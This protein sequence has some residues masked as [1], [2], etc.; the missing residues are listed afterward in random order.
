[1]FFRSCTIF[2]WFINRYTLWDVCNKE[3]LALRNNFRVTKKFLITMV[4]LCWFNVVTNRA[5]FLVFSVNSYVKMFFFHLTDF[6]IFF[7]H[8]PA[9]SALLTYK[10]NLDITRFIFCHISRLLRSR[11]LRQRVF[12]FTRIGLRPYQNSGTYRRVFLFH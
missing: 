1:M 3:H 5:L 6:A 8:V 11:G 12:F 4:H 2:S 7:C 10:N 9:L